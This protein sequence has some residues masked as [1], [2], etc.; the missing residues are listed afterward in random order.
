MAD[1]A[2]FAGVSSAHIS[3]GRSGFPS[4]GRRVAAGACRG[5]TARARLPDRGERAGRRRF[6]AL[7]RDPSDR[8]VSNT[9]DLLL[10][11]HAGDEAALVTLV[12]RDL[13]WIEAQARR[14]LGPRLRRRADT[15]DIV[16][17]TLIEVLRYGPRFVLSDRGHLRGLLARM[18][19]NVLRAQADHH[20]AQKRDLAREVGLGSAAA[21]PD[22]VLE[23]DPPA[24]ATAPDR[25]AERG[26]LRDWVRLAL[27]LLEPGDRDLIVWRDFDEQPFAAIA[28]RLGEGED[29]VRMRHRRALPKLARILRSLQRGS[30]TELV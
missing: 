20:G 24:G 15:Q 28:T 30:I 10:R 6:D 21:A 22:S 27:E 9:R 29:T 8:P 23:L 4:R 5:G 14:R 12:E 1:P 16:Q 11:W 25:A 18:V 3:P 19:E 26:E 13:D 7:P 17:E 2:T